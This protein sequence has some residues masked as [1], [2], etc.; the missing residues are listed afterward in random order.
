MQTRLYLAYA[1]WRRGMTLGVRVAVFDAAN[2]VFLIRHTYV[3]GWYFPGGGVEPGE[4]VAAAMERELMEEGGIGLEGPAELFGFYLN[5]VASKRDHVAFF[6]SRNWRQAHH[7]KIP[8]F[9]IAEAGFFAADSLPD[10]TTP[11]TRRR[12]EEIAGRLARSE[13]W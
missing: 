12:L 4:T 8:N 6:V 7:P 10:D 9:E 1:R 13:E 3:P 5:R 2:R 11:G